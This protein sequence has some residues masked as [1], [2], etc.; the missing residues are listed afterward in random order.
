MASKLQIVDPEFQPTA[1]PSERVQPTDWTRCILCQEVT[2][3]SLQCPAADTRLC[4]KGSGYLTLSQNILRFH[5]LHALPMPID[6]RR[7]DDGCGIEQSLQKHKAKWHK[8]CSI[9]FNTTKLQRAEKRQSTKDDDPLTKPKKFTRVNDPHERARQDVCFFCDETSSTDKLHNAS[10][11]QLDSRVRK[12]A[13]NLQDDR[14]LAKLSAGDMVAQDARYHARCLARL[15]NK[16]TALQDK[17]QSDTSYNI[18]HGI[19]FAE[20]VTFI[21]ELRMDEK[22][23]PVFKLSDLTK[24]YSSRLEQLDIEH[25][26]RVH[27]T[28][29]KNRI[30]AQF[31]DMSAHKEGREV[32]L[33]FNQ[34]IGLA[35]KGASKTNFDDEAICLANAAKIVR[36]DMLELTTKFTG[37]FQPNCQQS[38]VPKALLALVVMILDSP[39]IK[40]QSD[41]TSQAALSISQLLQYNSHVRRRKG[42][43]NPH[44]TKARETSLPMYVGITVH[45]R[46]GSSDLVDT[47]FNLGLS[48]SYDRV[49]DVSTDMANRVCELYNQKKLVCPANLLGGLFTTG[50][51]DNINHT[52][53]STTSAGAFNGTGIS[54]FQPR[55]QL[56]GTDLQ[57]L[58]IL[59]PAC[60][61][62]R[63]A[64]LPESYTTIPPIT[65][66]KKDA[67]VPPV[68]GALRGTGQAYSEA[69]QAEIRFVLW[70]LK[71][72]AHIS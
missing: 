30:L 6:I 13:L 36:R 43:V 70:N 27:S 46:T 3:E 14:L 22:I 60:P 59:E 56:P 54:L 9:K 71:F 1:G 34:D 65:L 20:L 69:F 26:S 50:G 2:S 19:A 21:E 15:Y 12:C 61:T 24:L 10:T 32:F 62:R 39:N 28:D 33:A 42:S 7:L 52:P 4:A 48:V 8:L 35:L 49:M 29:L 57:E 44:H 63:V 16:D 37:S 47:L 64:E 51:I 58:R 66:K 5:N 11:F 25:S 45:T 17:M 40:S 67:L 31:P 18:S 72:R 53:S 68:A 38:S 55:G 41:T 23:A